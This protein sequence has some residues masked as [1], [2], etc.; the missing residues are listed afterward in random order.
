VPVDGLDEANDAHPAEDHPHVP[1][2]AGTC[3]PVGDRRD[4]VD[5]GRVGGQDRR[6]V[7]DQ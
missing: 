5:G 4:A 1:A 6:D 3:G 7:T 2:P